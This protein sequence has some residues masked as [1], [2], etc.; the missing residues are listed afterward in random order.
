MAQSAWLGANPNANREMF[1]TLGVPVIN[2]IQVN[3]T[4]EEW[5]ESE[6]G[7]KIYKRT[8][9]LSIPEQMGMIQPIVTS[10]KEIS[11]QATGH[12]TKNAIVFSS[13]TLIEKSTKNVCAAE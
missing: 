8:N 6:K 5:M 10:S 9:N 7:I 13:Q 3:Q 11:D 2:L 12:K 1:E 4:T